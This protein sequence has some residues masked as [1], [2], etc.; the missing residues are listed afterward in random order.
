MRILLLSVLLPCFCLSCNRRDRELRILCGSSMAEP[1]QRIG[2]DFAKQRGVEAIFDLGGSETLLPRILAG[3]DADIF[4]CHDPFEQKV[5]D[6]GQW[7]GSVAVG[8]MRPVLLVKKGNPKKIG[9][10]A[11][12]GR[13]G[14]KIGVGRPDTSTCGKMFVD[15]L[16]KRGLYPQVQPQILLEG[17]GHVEI[18]N[19]LTEGPLDAAVVWNL[20]AVMYKDKVEIVPD[21]FRYD[22]IR[23]T[24][25]GLKQGANPALRDQFLKM[26]DTPQVK[27]IFQKFGYTD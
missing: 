13:S 20:V 26:C 18:A 27:S 4:I 1:G 2:N 8:T 12:L 5:K 21:S 6:A 25:V 9:S 7:A 19:G 22:P 23:V 16:E 3:V 10:V 17:R 15:M 14:L 11:D 24:V